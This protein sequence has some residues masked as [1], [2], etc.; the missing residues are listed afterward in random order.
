MNISFIPGGASAP[1]VDRAHGRTKPARR[2]RAPAPFLRR[3]DGA[4]LR[5]VVIAPRLGGWIDQRQV[6]AMPEAA[7]GAGCFS[8][9]FRARNSR[10]PA[11]ERP[12][13]ATSLVRQY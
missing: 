9:G 10:V 12:V 13:L 5:Q 8:R 6:N 1:V 2:H 3:R 11:H 7:L 4:D